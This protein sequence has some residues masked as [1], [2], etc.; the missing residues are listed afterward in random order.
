MLLHALGVELTQVLDNIADGNDLNIAAAQEAADMSA[1]LRTHT[2]EAEVDTLVRR[3]A[4]GGGRSENQRPANPGG[5]HAL[6]ELTTRETQR[7]G[8]GF[9]SGGR[10]S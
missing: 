7:S 2:D 4:W 6:D 8:H 1:S 9:S 10:D 5:R 3:D